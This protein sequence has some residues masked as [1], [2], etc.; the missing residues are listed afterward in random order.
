M[1]RQVIEPQHRVEYLSILD[2]DC[3]LDKALEP[4]LDDDTLQRLYRTMLLARRFDEFQLTLQ[5]QGRIGTFAPSSGQEAAQLGSTAALRKEDWVVPSFRELCATLWR[6]ASLEQILLYAAGYNEGADPGAESRDLPIAIPVASQI[7]HAVGLAY[8]ARYRDRD[9]V[10]MV[11]FGDGATSEGD[12]HEGLNFACVFNTATVFICQN[13]QWAIS[14][15]REHQ[16]HSKT[17]AQKALAYG[18]PG[19][20]VDGNDILAVYLASSEAVKRARKGDGPTLI[21]CI[22]YRL[23]AHTTADDPK[24]YRTPEEEE[25][26]KKCDP[27]RRFRHYLVNRG[28]LDD[29]AVEAMEKDIAEEMKQAWKSAEERMAT[30]TDPLVIFDHQFAE[31]SPYLRVQHDAF[32]NSPA[33]QDTEEGN[34]G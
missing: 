20:Q 9:D 19:I 2:S 3:Q 24:R 31:M 15:P 18:I 28:L 25:A 27:L 4:E 14:V 7:P 8:A 17:L 26:W 11:F 34:G 22:T 10:A 6:G 12:F 16:S 32:A 13:N 30:L 21:E 5:H 23:A 29:S 33:H 1:P